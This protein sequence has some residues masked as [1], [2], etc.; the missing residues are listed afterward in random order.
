MHTIISYPDPFHYHKGC[1]YIGFTTIRG[2]SEK[3]FDL[4]MYLKFLNVIGCDKILDIL[5][6]ASG[7]SLLSLLYSQ[8]RFSAGQ[9][10]R[11]QKLQ[12]CLI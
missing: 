2:I 9:S 4:T 6:F 8:I 1:L 3:V 12:Y 7:P 10:V 5:W 11:Y